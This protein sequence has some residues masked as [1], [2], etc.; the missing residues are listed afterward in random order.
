MS[1]SIFDWIQNSDATLILHTI[2]L[3]VSNIMMSILCM[4]EFEGK[5]ILL[6]VSD[7]Q[8]ISDCVGVTLPENMF[9][10]YTVNSSLLKE[11]VK[12]PCYIFID[13]LTLF[14]L[15]DLGTLLKTKSSDTKCVIFST[16]GVSEDDLTYFNKTFPKNNIGYFPLLDSGPKIDYQLCLSN[17]TDEQ[18]K[19]Y[20]NE[21]AKES[22]VKDTNIWIKSRANCKW[23]SMKV[24]FALDD[25]TINENN[26]SEILRTKYPKL[27][28]LILMI[29]LNQN[30]KHIIYTRYNLQ[31]LQNV[32]NWLKISY[33]KINMDETFET[34]KNTIRLYNQSEVEQYC[35]LLTN[36]I[37][38]DDIHNIEHLHF[39]EGVDYI[40]YRS[41]VSRIYL[42]K[43]YS[44]PIKTLSIYF[45]VAQMYDG[46][47][48]ADGIY[49]RKLTEKI[50][51]FTQIYQDNVKRSNIIHCSGSIG[52]C[53]NLT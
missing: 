18:T 45:H 21:T 40:Q 3:P 25:L 22:S 51:T 9:L 44:L 15:C 17:M 33:C 39:L 30:S 34:Q 42:R 12:F 36:T 27:F 29:C 38:V 26:F 52:L 2:T 14:R 47:V 28:N 1:V 49:Y 37:C 4:K 50:K 48:A 7:V 46:T 19:I 43:L 8:N 5:T 16:E 53:I 10:S 23:D 6:M 31:L 24:N 32:F 13:N 11:A 35:V 41:F 20:L